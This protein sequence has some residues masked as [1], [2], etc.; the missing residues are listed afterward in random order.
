VLFLFMGV[1]PDLE[2]T[3][4]ASR[5]SHAGLC[6]IIES[7]EQRQLTHRR[8]FD[9]KSRDRIESSANPRRFSA[10]RY[11]VQRSRFIGRISNEMSNDSHDTTE[12]HRTG[13]D[14]AAPASTEA[15][16]QPQPFI[17][18]PSRWDRWEPLAE[19]I[20]TLVLALATLATAWSGYQSARWGGEQS[21]KYSQAGAL[22]TESTRASTR[23]GQFAQIEIGL[24]VNWINAFAADDEALANFYQERFSPELTVAFD[25]WLATDPRNNP[26][27]P[28][29]PFSMP[30]YV[31]R[32]SEEAEQLELE[33]S[34]TFEEGTAANE[35]SDDYILN[36]VIL[37]SVLFLAGVQTRIN[38]VPARMVIIILGSLI[39]AFGL[40]N[41]ATYPIS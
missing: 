38:L 35:I 27:A 24:F 23:S 2:F 21:T 31:P 17:D 32:Y 28:K 36:T 14:E 39:L 6:V 4:R 12:S 7:W 40:Y 19:I 41:I 10:E 9:P 26:D 8:N 33:A 30:E 34:K 16:Y 29:S 22:R 1:G 18:L 13:A 37:A 15:Q 5:L 25:A 3:N 20:A 11:L